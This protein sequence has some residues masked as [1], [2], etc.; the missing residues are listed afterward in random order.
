MSEYRPI[1]THITVEREIFAN[2]Q[3]LV[4]RTTITHGFNFCGQW[5]C[6]LC[7]SLYMEEYGW[8]CVVRLQNEGDRELQNRQLRSQLP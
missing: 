2:G 7:F 4:L 5:Q 1:H 3:I 8:Q 6:Q